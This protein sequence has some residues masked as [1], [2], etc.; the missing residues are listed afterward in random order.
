MAFEGLIHR[1][2]SLVQRF[3]QTCSGPF[4]LALAGRAQQAQLTYGYA[5]LELATVEVLVLDDRLVRMAGLQVVTGA[6]AEGGLLA[7]EAPK[8]AASPG[9]DAVPVQP[10]KAG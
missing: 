6:Y 8:S 9:E 3:E 10:S 1:F 5:L 7:K 4:G 2:D